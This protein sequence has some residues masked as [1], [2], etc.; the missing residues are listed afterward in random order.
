MIQNC[1]GADVGFKAKWKTEVSAQALI[2]C[3]FARI[4]SSLESASS[5]KTAL[6]HM[7]SMNFCRKSTY[8][9]STR[10]SSANRS[11]SHSTVLTGRDAN[12]FTQLF[13]ISQRRNNNARP[14]K[15]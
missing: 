11:M 7:A 14:T 15:K 3:R 8:L 13:K 1:P 4:G 6:L 5:A 12:S 9:P 2:F 10:P